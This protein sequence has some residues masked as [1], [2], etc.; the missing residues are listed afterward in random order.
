MSDP[1]GAFVL[2][3]LEVRPGDVL[4]AEGPLHATLRRPMP[5]AGELDVALVL[6]K[7]AILDRLVAWARRR[8]KPFDARP[9]P[10]PGHVRRAA[11]AELG[12]ALWADAVERTAYGAGV[13]NEEAQRAVDRLAPPDPA[14]PALPSGA[15]RRPR[16]GAG[17]R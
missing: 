1:A 12:V 9:E 3:P 6:R 7:R 16:P 5:P 13:V 4:L 8:G 10:T 11:A 2:P 17:P 15:A 14:H